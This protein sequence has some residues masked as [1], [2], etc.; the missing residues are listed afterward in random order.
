VHLSSTGFS[1]GDTAAFFVTVSNAGPFSLADLDVELSF[2]SILS[3][4]EASP[5]P[6]GITSG[7]VTWDLAGLDPFEVAQFVVR[8]QI[9]ADPL[10]L[11]TELQASAT[12]T[13]TIPDTDP[14][15]DTYVLPDLVIGPFD[16]NDK[17]ALTSSRSSLS[18]FV[19]EVDEYIDYTVRFQNTGSAPAEYVAVLDTVSRLLDLGSFQLLAASHSVTTSLEEGRVLRFAFPDIDLPDSTSDLVGSQGFV[20]FRL[21]PMNGLV[22]GEDIPNAADIY[23]DFNEAV[24]TNTAMLTVETISGIPDHID[25]HLVLAPNPAC[26]R[27]RIVGPSVL[28]S[29][30][31]VLDLRGRAVLELPRSGGSREVEISS[32]APGMYVVRSRNEQGAVRQAR[33]VKY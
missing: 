1:I 7:T 18:A 14:G 23:F 31:D 6:A 24:R 16:P 19:L 11:G 29:T 22:V 28:N 5:Q 13:S 30:L 32:L 21:K 25:E 4:M 15:N 2:S 33:F 8:V 17:R 27:I 26:D 12:I 9:P 20:S 3:F 10:L